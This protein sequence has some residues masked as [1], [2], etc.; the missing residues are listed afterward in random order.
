MGDR[1]RPQ[2]RR[3]LVIGAGAAVGGAWALGVLCAWAETEEA[4]VTAF[5]VV[6]GTSAGSVLAALLGSG[7][8]PRAVAD[9]LSCGAGRGIPAEAVSPVDVP[10]RVLRALTDIPRPI[11]FPGNLR[12]AART[13]GQPGR[14]TV[15]AAAAALAPRGRG[16]LAPVGE[17]I[18]EVCGHEGWTVR[19]RTWMVAMDF[20]S[21]RRV[22]FGA[23]GQPVT[24]PSEA[25]MASC[26]V[27]GVFPPRQIGHR[28]YVDGGAVSVT[29]ADVLAEE[30]LDEVLVLAPMATAA[31]DPRRS[32]AAR[33][34]RRLRQHL[35]QRVQWEVARLTAA[36]TT[37]R[38]LA[39]TAEDLAVMGADLMDARRRRSVFE[40]A[41]RTGTTRFL[42]AAPVPIDGVA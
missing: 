36:G 22:V 31:P 40:T 11:P 32:P 4:D 21:G 10:G 17:L 14:H 15:R 9:M 2:P 30:G 12:L 39:P 5:E 41:V 33:L 29:N 34:D 28:R 24:S 7:M 16:S 23:A 20:D 8:P 25:V 42:Q 26:S 13:L 3:G 18:D 35:D 19:P 1:V 27:P 6:V 38:V 37:V